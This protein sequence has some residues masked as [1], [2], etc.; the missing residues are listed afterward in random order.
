MRAMPN[1]TQLALARKKRR[2]LAIALAYRASRLL[3]LLLGESTALRFFLNGAWLFHRFAHEASVSLFGDVFRCSALG[4]TPDIL[5]GV[6]P[7]GAT[8]LDLGC[9]TGRWSIAASECAS[10]VVGV[11]YDHELI[12]EA[13]SRHQVPHVE[14]RLADIES[15]LSATL[16]G[17]RFDVILALHVLEHVEKADELL[18]EL[19]MVGN[20]L[21]VE[22]PDFGADA[23][24]RV[25][26]TLGTRFYT[27]ADHVREYTAETLTAQ[28][29]NSGWSVSWIDTRGGALVALCTPSSASHGNR[30]A[31][32]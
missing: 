10:R 26:V 31:V 15:T 5:R 25:R 4:V 29:L 28:L 2:S 20:T 7:Q 23:L 3:R 11:D 13:R 17:E 19:T 27:D 16:A 18:R 1:A 6:V 14:F 24:N 32:C 9:G 8:V 12:A 30:E 22:V 21:L